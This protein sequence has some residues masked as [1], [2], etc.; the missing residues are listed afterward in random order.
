MV[1]VIVVV[2]LVAAMALMGYLFSE[3]QKASAAAAKFQGAASTSRWDQL[4]QHFGE[5]NA[6]SIISGK[7]WVGATTEMVIAMHGGPAA[8]VQQGSA[9]GTREFLKYYPLANTFGQGFQL[10]VIV[11][12]GVVTG[13]ESQ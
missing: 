10:V 2:V 7:L 9:A 11:D 3:S 5:Q 12:N 8:R 4:V 6:R 1:A 13:W